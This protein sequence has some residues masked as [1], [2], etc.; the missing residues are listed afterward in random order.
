MDGTNDF[1]K[2]GVDA[3]VNVVLDNA[4]NGS[5][6]LMHDGGGDRSQTIQAVDKLIP[7]LQKRGYRFVTIDELIE[8]RK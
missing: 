7:E 5:I 1:S 3:I 6:V 2:P 4:E 8:L